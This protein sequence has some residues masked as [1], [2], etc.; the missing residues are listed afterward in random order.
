MTTIVVASVTALVSNKIST[1]QYTKPKTEARIGTTIYTKLLAKKNF[2]K[3]N[4]EFEGK[5]ESSKNEKTSL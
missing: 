1:G 2:V 5:K 4:E 3:L